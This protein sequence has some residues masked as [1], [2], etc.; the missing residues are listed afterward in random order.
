MTAVVEDH[1]RRYP[2]MQVE[3]VY[4]LVHQAAFGNGH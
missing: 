1:L 3:D 2:A 4:K